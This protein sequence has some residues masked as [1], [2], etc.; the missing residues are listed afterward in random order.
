MIT[1]YHLA[2][3]MQG[4]PV[5]SPILPVELE[6]HLPPIGDYAPPED[7]RGI[8]DVR[9]RD[10]WAQTLRVAVLC[11]CLDMAVNEIPPTLWLG[12]TTK[13]ETSWPTS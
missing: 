1:E 5:M 4:S 12:P 10:N 9:V 8:T 13:G 6:E 3:V 7:H 11:H 2:C